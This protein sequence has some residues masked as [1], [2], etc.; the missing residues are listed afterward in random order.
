MFGKP[1]LVGGFNPSENISQN[2]NLP[3]IGVKIK[4][5]KPPPSYALEV[6]NAWIPKIMEVWSQWFSTLN[7]QPF[8]PEAIASFHK[9]LVRDHGASKCIKHWPGHFMGWPGALRQWEPED[10]PFSGKQP[11][12]TRMGMRNYANHGIIKNTGESVAVPFSHLISMISMKCMW[13]K[14]FRPGN[15][16]GCFLT[17]NF[18][19]NQILYITD[20]I[21]YIIYIYI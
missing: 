14:F 2:G 8:F 1:Y 5:L 11:Q 17:C 6:M 12:K 10:S 18:L 21:R 19:T 4:K 20:N 15:G 16:H 9:A 3:Q 13:R 7:S